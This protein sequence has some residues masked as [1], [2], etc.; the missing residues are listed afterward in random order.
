MKKITFCSIFILSLILSGCS[1]QL[2]SEETSSS[3]Y[4]NIQPTLSKSVEYASDSD[5]F[6]LDAATK[7]ITIS[8]NLTGK[9]IYYAQVNKSSSDIPSN[10]VRYISESGARRSAS[11][12][13]V[14]EIPENEKEEFSGKEEGCQLF[15]NFAPEFLPANHRSSSEITGA[16]KA[17]LSYE[18]AVTKKRVNHISTDSKFAKTE[19]TLMAFNDICNVWISD[20]DSFI[21]EEEKI[22]I[23]ETYAETF[24]EIYPI[25]RNV[26]GYESDY[27]Y[28]SVYGNKSPLSS[29]SDTGSKINIVICDL[30]ND[31]KKGG[32][33]GLFSSLDYYMNGLEFS[34]ITVTNSNEGKYFY[35]DSYF[36]K[37]KFNISI[38]TLAHEFQHMIC[39]GMKIMKNIAID[40]NFNEMLSMLC[41]D[42]MQ[43][44]LGINDSS[45][46]KARLKQF[47]SQYHN[48]GFR[49]FENTSLSYANAYS[50]GAWLCRQYGGAALVR[51]MMFN[52]KGNNDCIV[53]AVNKLNGTSFTF[54]QL[55]SQFVMAC[56][57]SSKYTFN[58]DA[59]QTLTYCENGISY[60]YP[61]EAISIENPVVFLNFSVSTLSDSYGLL[62]KNYSCPG[63]NE[64]SITL[65]FETL[66]GMTDT[67]TTT[68]IYIK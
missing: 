62:I 51:E 35:I 18:V 68:Y 36:A 54:D 60:D 37:N 12:E 33:I 7:S 31:G 14:K 58:Q 52:S 46:P 41:E 26:F 65:N 5:F 43:E 6:I 22:S 48:A 63:E 40:T 57:G 21:S 11:E 17:Q 15:H 64:T 24:Q 19:T 45:S 61:M 44:Y 38:S 42:M 50:L 59:G 30:Y 28:S 27:L 67:G 55:F 3:S 39:F 53:D 16:S 32:T 34:N 13:E 4:E 66:S 23:A 10:M 49:S 20:N 25:I 9:S 2:D 47:V 56:L 8:G 1:F 29:A